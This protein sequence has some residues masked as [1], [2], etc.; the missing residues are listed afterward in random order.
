MIDQDGHCDGLDLRTHADVLSPKPLKPPKRTDE[1]SRLAQDAN[2]TYL[3]LFAPPPPTATR[4]PSRDSPVSTYPTTQPRFD[5][6]DFDPVAIFGGVLGDDAGAGDDSEISAEALQNALITAQLTSFQLE[7]EQQQQ[8]EA[9]QQQ[10]TEQHQAA[11][12]ALGHVDAFAEYTHHHHHDEGGEHA[13]MSGIDDEHAAELHAIMDGLAAASSA[14]AS[15]SIAAADDDGM[16]L[17][18]E[19]DFMLEPSVPPVICSQLVEVMRTLDAY[20]RL[21][22]SPALG[23]L[24]PPLTSALA[25]IQHFASCESCSTAPAWTLPQLALTSRTCT[26]LAGKHPLTPAPLELSIAGGRTAGTGLPPEIEV[27][28]VD[29]VWATWRGATV[30]K[31]LTRLQI[32]AMAENARIKEQG[33]QDEMSPVVLRGQTMLKGL[34]RLQ[35]YMATH[36]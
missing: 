13:D 21:P 20:R 3:S 17:E 14:S 32:L 15:G 35:K 8:Q 5:L 24:F 33:E 23:E 22:E 27:H 12:A 1:A 4:S 2:E 34:A 26:L 29:I 16:E 19:A 25:S 9:E 7:L 11:A 36:L 30:Q 18:D 31:A 6:A 28:V 10:Q